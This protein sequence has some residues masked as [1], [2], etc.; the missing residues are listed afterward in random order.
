MEKPMTAIR[1]LS[2]LATIGLALLGPA[3][4]ASAYVIEALTSIPSEQGRDKATLERAIRAAVDDV[5]THAV[6]FT[7]TVVSLR[8]AK[9]V[10]DRIY[11]FVLIA[12]AAGEQELEA[13]KAEPDPEGR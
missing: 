8:E 13:L 7:P 1:S 11:L 3:G 12:D 4:P 6:G 5:T 10:G 2:I 9:L